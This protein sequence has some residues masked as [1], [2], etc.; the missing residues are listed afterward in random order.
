[1]TYTLTAADYVYLDRV[2]EQYD[3]IKAFIASHRDHPG[4]DRH[5]TK[6]PGIPG[7]VRLLNERVQT[8]VGLRKHDSAAQL[9]ERKVRKAYKVPAMTP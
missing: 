7:T 2:N 5:A 8:L 6:R 1:M 4:S 9:I 3:R